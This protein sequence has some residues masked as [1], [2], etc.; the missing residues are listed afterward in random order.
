MY[1]RHD[2]AHPHYIMVACW[3]LDYVRLAGFFWMNFWIV[4]TC[5]R[6]MLTKKSDFRFS[7]SHEFPF[8][9]HENRIFQGGVP[10]HTAVDFCNRRVWAS[11][12]TKS[13]KGYTEKQGERREREVDVAKNLPPP[14]ELTSHFTEHKINIFSSLVSPP[15]SSSHKND[16]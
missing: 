11:V 6:N 1:F 14:L 4:Q 13:L 7:V 3:L 8:F 5:E 16:G 2:L 9:A 15:P 10:A 12:S